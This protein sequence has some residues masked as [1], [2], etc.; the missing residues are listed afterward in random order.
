MASTD[1]L[2]FIS[3]RTPGSIVTEWAFFCVDMLNS[4]KEH[5]LALQDGKFLVEFHTCHSNNKY[6][7]AINQSYW[8]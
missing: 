4:L 8:L 6:F 7:S 1:K 5:P 2:F 3:H